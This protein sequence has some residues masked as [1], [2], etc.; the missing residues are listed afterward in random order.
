MVAHLEHVRPQVDAR[1]QELLLHRR[2]DVAREQDAAPCGLDGQDQRAVVARRPPSGGHRGRLGRPE[3]RD[4]EISRAFGAVSRTALANRNAP[5]P[6]RRTQRVERGLRSGATG[7]PDL[8]H[9]ECREDGRGAPPVIQIRV[10]DGQHVDPPDPESAQR[11]RHGAASGIVPAGQRRSRVDQQHAAPALDQDRVPEP[12]IEGNHAGR[13]RRELRGRRALQHGGHAA[14]DAHAA[15]GAAHAQCG[16]RTRDRQQEPGKGGPRQARRHQLGHG[17]GKRIRGPAECHQR[18]LRH[19]GERREQRRRDRVRCEQGQR[20]RQQRAGQQDPGRPRHADEVG[21]QRR[22]PDEPA[23][24]GHE[25][26][27]DRERRGRCAHQTDR[28]PRDRPGT[29]RPIRGLPQAQQERGARG[30][31]E[32]RAGLEQAARIHGQDHQ[33][34]RPQG[35][36]RSAGTAAQ[37]RPGER[38]EEH[39]GPPHRRREAG[40]QT[41]GK[42]QP[43]RGGEGRGPRVKAHRERP[44]AREDRPRA[45][46]GQRGDQGEVQTRDRQQVRRAQTGERIARLGTESRAIAHAQGGEQRAARPLCAEPVGRPPTRPL[47]SG[48]QAGLRPDPH[49]ESRIDQPSPRADAAPLAPPLGAAPS[50]IAQAAGR[51]HAQAGAHPLSG[52]HIAEPAARSRGPGDP[53]RLHHPDARGKGRLALPHHQRTAELDRAPARASFRLTDGALRDHLA[54][55]DRSVAG[56]PLQSRA[57]GEGPGGGGGDDHEQHAQCRMAAQEKSEPQT[58][59]GSA[60]RRRRRDRGPVRGDDAH[61]Q[62]EGAARKEARHATTRDRGRSG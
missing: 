58:A 22:G 25:G 52:G 46:V 40:E 33:S 59:R 62:G 54:H 47:D 17:K 35:I 23:I 14:G 56:R 7:N 18:S 11:R 6:G 48:A 12:D 28:A 55:G 26:R 2:P 32:L 24:D 53:N 4:R 1:G 57:E 27:R 19:E 49:P 16:E 15:R 10:G 41:V 29:P 51:P 5:R 21:Q 30:E 44:R 13:E 61:R 42:G 43:D 37:G 39:A 34:S 3:G 9:G 36:D 38:E 31:G 45:G 60:Q 20:R 50:G 8:P